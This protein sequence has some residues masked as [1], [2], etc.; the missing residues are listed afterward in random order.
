MGVRLGLGALL[1]A[2]GADDLH[3][4]P[5]PWYRDL[6]IGLPLDPPRAVSTAVSERLCDCLAEAHVSCVG[7][8]A[9]VVTEDQFNHRVARTRNKADLVVEQVLR[10]IS[11]A[12]AQSGPN[13]LHVYVDRLSER[14]R[15]PAPRD[16]RQR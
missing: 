4:G 2:L 14:G 1:A 16:Q 15:H 7:L 3:A 6:G 10:H 8:R 9:G 13:D 11:W 5:M 12:V